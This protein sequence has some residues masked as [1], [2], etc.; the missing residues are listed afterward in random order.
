MHTHIHTYIRIHIR[1]HTHI[2][3]LHDVRLGMGR[4]TVE[5]SAVFAAYGA[6]LSP[7]VQK[8]HFVIDRIQAFLERQLGVSSIAIAACIRV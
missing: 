8:K 7:S 1:I 6:V 5:V 3:T 4:Q 2:D